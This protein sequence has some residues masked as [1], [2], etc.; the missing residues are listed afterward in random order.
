VQLF[1]CSAHSR[2]PRDQIQILCRT[3]FTFA[4]DCAL[5]AFREEIICLQWYLYFYIVGVLVHSSYIYS[6]LPEPF[7]SSPQWLVRKS[8]RQSIW[9]SAAASWGLVGS[10][11]AT[12][13]HVHGSLNII[14]YT[15]DWKVDAAC[16]TEHSSQIFIVILVAFIWEFMTGDIMQRRWVMYPNACKDI[17]WAE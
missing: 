8:Q 6:Y 11:F 17:W 10:M 13:P 4:S 14:E 12:C 16:S 9:D 3:L 2:R 1:S 15:S 5:L 7:D